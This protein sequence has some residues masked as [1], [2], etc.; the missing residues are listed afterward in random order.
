M[1]DHTFIFVHTMNFCLHDKN[2]CPHNEFL[3]TRWIFV[4]DTTV[5]MKIV[6]LYIYKCS[7]QPKV[8]FLYARRALPTS[9][10]VCSHVLFEQKL[11]LVSVLWYF[12]ILK[13][14]IFCLRS[15]RSHFTTNEY[16]LRDCF[17]WKRM[18]KARSTVPIRGP[19]SIWARSYAR[20]TKTFFL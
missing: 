7:N 14:L 4:H 3:S 5:R 19:N 20:I 10:T 13:W 15:N 9:S 8:D 2:F 12:S 1:H 11:N 6:S 17:C 18:G 16:F